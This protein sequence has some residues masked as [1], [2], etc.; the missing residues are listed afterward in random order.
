[1]SIWLRFSVASSGRHNPPLLWSHNA[2]LSLLSS[3]RQLSL[4]RQSQKSHVNRYTEDDNN[5]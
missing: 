3:L 2:S 4:L 1:M 5:T